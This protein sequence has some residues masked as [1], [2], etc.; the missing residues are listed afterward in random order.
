M[1]WFLPDPALASLVS[2]VTV[3]DELAHLLC[4]CLP[5]GDSDVRAEACVCDLLS[6]WQRMRVTWGV[7]SAR[8]LLMAP[9]R[10]HGDA[11]EH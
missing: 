11:W 5:R 8:E 9:G 2:A 7:P 4:W 10:C 6:P 3:P 1:S